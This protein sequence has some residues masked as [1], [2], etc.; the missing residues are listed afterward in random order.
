MRSMKLLLAGEMCF[1]VIDS[2][3]MVIIPVTII[4]GTLTC[5]AVMGFTAPSCNGFNPSVQHCP[6]AQRVY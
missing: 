1:V 2:D 4:I 3:M 6:Y 5:V